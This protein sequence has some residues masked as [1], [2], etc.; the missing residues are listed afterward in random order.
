MAQSCLRR[1]DAVAGDL[2]NI[3]AVEIRDV[4]V[5]VPIDSDSTKSFQLSA[6][7]WTPIAGVAVSSV[8]GEG[9]DDSTRGN[10]SNP[11]R[12]GNVQVAEGIRGRNKGRIHL[13][14]S[15]RT[16]VAGVA[17]RPVP[18]HSGD[19]S[20]GGDPSYPV[21][22]RQEEIAGCIGSHGTRNLSAGRRAAVAGVT[23][24]EVAGDTR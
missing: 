18:G 14:G 19:D 9:G 21:R 16:T 20:V 1:D 13:R 8:P 2:A 3:P 6:G 24:S 10:P 17:A 12:F 11:E 5:A 22:S 7:G 4:E 23:W 15:G